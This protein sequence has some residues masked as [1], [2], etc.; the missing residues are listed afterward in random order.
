MKA[1]VHYDSEVMTPVQRNIRNNPSKSL[2]LRKN[3]VIT[4]DDG[5]LTSSFMNIFGIFTRV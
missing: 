2:R 5:K 1:P 3:Q 4:A